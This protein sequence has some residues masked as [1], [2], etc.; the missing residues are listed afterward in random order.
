MT[1]IDIESYGEHIGMNND[2]ER[3]TVSTSLAKY[4]TV[5]LDLAES[6]GM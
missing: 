3:S 2:L 6:I 5:L 1:V 4:S